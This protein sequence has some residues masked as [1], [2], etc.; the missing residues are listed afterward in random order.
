MRNIPINH[1]QYQAEVKQYPKKKL[2]N[3]HGLIS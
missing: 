3:L 1:C 2:K